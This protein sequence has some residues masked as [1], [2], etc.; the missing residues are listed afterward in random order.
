MGHLQESA[1]F[2]LGPS[3]GS[4]KDSQSYRMTVVLDLFRCHRIWITFMAQNVVM[5][6]L[7]IVDVLDNFIKAFGARSSSVFQGTDR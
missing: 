2:V 7:L 4:I 6:V 3:S 1:G 5:E